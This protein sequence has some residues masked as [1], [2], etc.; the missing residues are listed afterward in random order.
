MAVAEDGLALSVEVSNRFFAREDRYYARVMGT[1]GSGSLP[2]LQVY[3]QVGGRPMDVTPKQ[4]RPRGGENPYANAYR[5][6]IDHFVR[7]VQGRAEAPL[8]E[9]QATLMY[10][11]QAAYRAAESGEEVTL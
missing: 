9:E 5:R 10:L 11:I 7:A 4:P 6:Q 3:R 8:P 2:P 1:E